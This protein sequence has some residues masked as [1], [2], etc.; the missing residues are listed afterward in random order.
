M[1]SAFSHREDHPMRRLPV[2][3]WISN[4]AAVL[5]GRWGDVTQHADTVGCSRQTIYQHAERVEQAVTDLTDG[6]PTRQELLHEVQA[7]RQENRQ[8]W[9]WLGQ[10]IEFPQA[11]RRHFAVVAAAMGLSSRQI[12]RLLAII[13]PA[14]LGPGHATVRRWVHH[15][16]VKA[17]RLLKRLD[18]ACKTLVIVACLDEIF[19]RRQPVLVA[20]E[21]QSMAWVLGQRARDRSGPTWAAALQEW[22]ALLA[23]VADGGTGLHAGLSLVQQQRHESR[24]AP[25]EVGLD[26]FHTQRDAHRLLRSIWNRADGL[27]TK[28]E[29]ADRHV[30]EDKQQGRDARKAAARARRA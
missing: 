1:N 24:R 29:D 30:R 10:T 4:A 22:P 15:E 8:L 18:R 13:L 28:A 16:A 26:I 19:F 21:P 6:G 27:W 17:G 20:V 3:V 2:A 23:V 7:L 5:F 14:A 11:A 25:L 9:E 12:A